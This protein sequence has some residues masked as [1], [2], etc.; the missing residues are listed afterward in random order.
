VRRY[1]E[2]VEVQHVTADEATLA[3]RRAARV[4]APS[5][6]WLKGRATTAARFAE[7]FG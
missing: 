3:A 2:R 5:P 7:K 4:W 1:V 6:A